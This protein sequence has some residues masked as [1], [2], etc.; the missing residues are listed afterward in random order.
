MFCGGKT[1]ADQWAAFGEISKRFK[2]WR[3]HNLLHCTLTA[4][5]KNDMESEML[6]LIPEE[7]EVCDVLARRFL[8]TFNATHPVVDSVVFEAEVEEFWVRREV[9]S[10]MWL[11]LFIAILALGYQLPVIPLPEGVSRRGRA[12]GR[13]LTATVRSFIFAS[14]AATKRPDY[15]CFQLL[16]LLILS[17]SLELDWVDG[18]DVKHGLLSL[19]SR[20]AF[21]MGLHRDPSFANGITATEARLRRMVSF[22]VLCLILQCLNLSPALDHVQVYRPGALYAVWS[23]FSIK[24]S[25]L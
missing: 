23:A 8:I 18:N 21:T 10:T 22:H 5:V 14:P 6:R 19:T 13:E 11:G 2:G 4:S 9:K 20:L 15:K 7:R 24:R 17:Q 25:G 1:F 16:L 12:Y 3:S